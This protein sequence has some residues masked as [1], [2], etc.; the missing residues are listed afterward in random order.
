MKELRAIWLGKMKTLN[1]HP[2]NRYY[3]EKLSEVNEEFYKKAFRK[4]PRQ[5]KKYFLRES[6]KGG[7]SAPINAKNVEKLLAMLEEDPNGLAIVCVSE[8]DAEKNPSLKIIT[9]DGFS[10]DD[11]SYPLK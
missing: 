5:I 4:T 9:L 11:D 2:I 6:L 1:D 3:C 7:A 8:F 10:C